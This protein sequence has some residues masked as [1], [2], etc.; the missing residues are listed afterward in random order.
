LSVGGSTNNIEDVTPKN[1]PE[2]LPVLICAEL[3]TVPAG[4]PVGSTN[5]AVVA[6]LAVPNN[7]PVMVLAVI[8]PVTTN[9]PVISNPLGKDRY[10]VNDDAVS[11][12]VATEAVP[13]NEPV[14]LP[15]NEPVMGVYTE[16][17]CNLCVIIVS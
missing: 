6:L 5:D 2:K 11:A 10:P 8:L 15:D 3:D 7:D 17:E 12:V 4:S 1:D 14:T 13:C 9:D 16:S